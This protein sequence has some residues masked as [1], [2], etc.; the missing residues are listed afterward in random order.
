MKK[1]IAVICLLFLTSC[2]YFKKWN[3]PLS[4]AEISVNWAQVQVEIAD[5]F[6]K[7]KVWLM[8][9]ESM[10]ENQWMLFVWNNTDRRSFWMKN[11]LIPLDIIFVDE[12][13]KVLNIEE[14]EPCKEDPCTNYKSEWIAQYVLEVN[15]WWTKENNVKVGDVLKID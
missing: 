4:M 3:S 9:R 6:E 10:P 14:A 13:Q 12:N 8:H 11:A 7:R 2:T 1:T 5:T 15:Q